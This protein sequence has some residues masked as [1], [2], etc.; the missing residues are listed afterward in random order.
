MLI[1][2]SAYIFGF[3]WFKNTNDWIEIEKLVAES[4]QVFNSIG[5]VRE[6]SPSL[7][8]YSFSMHGGWAKVN[9]NV[10]VL[11]DI[12]KETFNIKAERKNWKW[13][14]VSVSKI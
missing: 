1:V 12:K 2:M 3:Y 10:D 11:G 6:I 13:M 8:W 9:L 7:F 14:L 5:N 4:P